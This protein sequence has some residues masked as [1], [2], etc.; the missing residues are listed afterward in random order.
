NRFVSPTPFDVQASIEYLLMAVAGGLGHLSGALVGAAVVLVMKN[1]V[2]DTLPLIT[3]RGGQFEA[4]VFAILFILL[5]QYARG[6]VMGL[7]ARWTRQ[8]FAPPP[9][10]KLAVPREPLPRRQLP[11]RG[12]RILSVQAATKRFG[13]LVAV[14]EVGFDVNAGEIIGLIGPNGA[15]KSTMFNLVTGTLPMTSGKVEFLG[16]DIT[17]LAQQRIA[18][19]GMARTFQHVKL[20]PQMSLLDN[21]ALGAHA[22]SGAGLLAAGLR[23][24]RRE[25][26]QIMAE[27]WAQ[28]ERIGLADRA[29][30]RAG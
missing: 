23:L 6:G 29:H 12:E 18:R 3:A 7:L 8:R 17:G 28:L 19:L 5:L 4:V 2:Q 20:R 14:N 9:M 26:A 11:G 22:R 1:V 30:E 27:A 24:D 15:G 13:G 21:V 25:E 10:P 16:R